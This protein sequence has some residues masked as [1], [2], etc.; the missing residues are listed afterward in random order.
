MRKNELIKS[1]ATINRTK[2]ARNT[3]ARVRFCV[4]CRKCWEYLSI[5][6]NSRK[7]REVRYY[8][9]F[10]TYGKEKQKCDRCKGE[11]NGKNVVDKLSV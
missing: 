6:T 10:P 11:K 4:K 2:E 5:D 8:K 1:T 3:D 9:D 7:K